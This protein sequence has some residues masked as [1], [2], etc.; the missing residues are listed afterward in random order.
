MRDVG[1]KRQQGE[2]V[3]VQKKVDFDCD[4]ERSRVACL[5]SQKETRLFEL[6]SVCTSLS[7][8][9]P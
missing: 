3:E 6:S 7:L 5:A 4:R 8:R 1:T 9:A 2:E